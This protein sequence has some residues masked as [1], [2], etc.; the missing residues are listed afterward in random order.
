M[1][2]STQSDF[3]MLVRKYSST[4]GERYAQMMEEDYN[5]G[6]M[7]IAFENFLTNLASANAKVSAE[8][9]EKIRLIAEL[10]NVLDDPTGKGRFW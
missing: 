4:V 1:E 5:S 7:Q 8:D 10:L 2:S 6:E 3:V 9:R